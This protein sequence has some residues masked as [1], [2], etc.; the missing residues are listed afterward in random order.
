[1]LGLGLGGSC[2]EPLVRSCFAWAADHQG[3][4]LLRTN[5][6]LA[7]GPEASPWPSWQVLSLQERLM[8]DA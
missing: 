3:Q 8:S 2:S 6:D 5:P 1:M 4:L 7:Q